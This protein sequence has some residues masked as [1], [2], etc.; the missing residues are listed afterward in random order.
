MKIINDHSTVHSSYLHLSNRL[1]STGTCTKRHYKHINHGVMS[2]H[3]GGLFGDS[4]YMSNG[5]Q[6]SGNSPRHNYK[7]VVSA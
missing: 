4:I 5:G 1:T 2:D 3:D 7:L 6:S